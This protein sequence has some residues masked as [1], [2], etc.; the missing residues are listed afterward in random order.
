[1]ARGA[2]N[3]NFFSSPDIAANPSNL[4][5]IRARHLHKYD[6]EA[7]GRHDY[8]FVESFRLDNFAGE[9][10]LDPVEVAEFKY[11]T[12]EELRRLY[13]EEPAS[14]TPWLRSE[15]NMFAGQGFESIRTTKGV[16]DPS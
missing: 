4:V 13:E 9:V 8:E 5:R 10:K 1:M 3:A 15:L 6:D 14:L 16:E 11:T 2:G 7:R 12:L